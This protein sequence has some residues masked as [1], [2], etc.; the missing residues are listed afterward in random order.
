MRRDRARVTIPEPIPNRLRFE[1]I[2]QNLLKIILQLN[3][4]RPIKN[5]AGREPEIIRPIA[6]PTHYPMLKN[7]QLNT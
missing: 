4:T 6:I 1:K 3:Q 5:G 2:N 7:K